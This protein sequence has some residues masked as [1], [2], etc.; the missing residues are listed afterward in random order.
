MERLAEAIAHAR[1]QELIDDIW[2]FKSEPR[3]LA[4]MEARNLVEQDDGVAKGS[5]NV[6]CGLGRESANLVWLEG[7]AKD[8]ADLPYILERESANLIGLEGVA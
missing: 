5:A 3:Y 4:V 6:P 1:I 8:S 2:W 7:V